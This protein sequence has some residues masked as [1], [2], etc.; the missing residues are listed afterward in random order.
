MG[1]SL[2]V[3]AT[4]PEPQTA[5]WAVKWWMQRHKETLERV[6]SAEVDLLWI[7]D[8]ITDGWDDDAGLAVWNKVYG[9]RKPFNLGIGGDRTEQVIWRLRHGEVEGLAPRVVVLMIGTNNTGHRMDPAQETARG[10]QIILNEIRTRLP[11]ARILLL[12][13]FPRGAT[14]ED[15]KRQRNEAV[16]NII[17]QFEDGEMIHYLNINPYFLD[18][19][20]ILSSEIMPDLLH[21][22]PKGYQIWADAMEPKLASLLND[23]K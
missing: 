13:I 15:P 11:E 1:S 12:G 17:R 9:N 10:I 2:A 18:G 21:L 6:K 14:P 4:T 19:A 20:G 7:G 3:P 8:S 16:N 22:S 5:E 23:S